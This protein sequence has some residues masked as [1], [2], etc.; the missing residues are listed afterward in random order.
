MRLRSVQLATFAF[1]CLL[2]T[3]M[4]AEAPAAF[5]KTSHKSS[6]AAKKSAAKKKAP[7][8]SI[9]TVQ[10]QLA[11]LGYYTGSVDGKNGPMTK[12]AVKDF[13]K[14]KGLKATGAL[15]SK[16][17][18]TLAQAAYTVRGADYYAAK[19]ASSG[20]SL[21]A[22]GSLGTLTSVEP[23]VREP[24]PFATRYGTFAVTEDE[25]AGQMKNYT[26]SL[27]GQAVLTVTNQA[28]PLRNSGTFQVGD[29]D[30]IVLTTY[31]GRPN[32]LYDN[33]LIVVRA[34]GAVLKYNIP[35]C[36]AETSGEV[37]DL[38]FFINFA[39]G[40]DGSKPGVIWRYYR[41]TLNALL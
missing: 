17:V 4:V 28:G 27:N 40:Y 18:S 9:H 7:S 26:L 6:A 10:S 20:R 19:P 29:E 37:K 22:G 8:T 31:T 41:G 5:A 1:A 30:A 3:A 12:R 32:C 25:V 35:V 23:V 33:N 15:D 34:D 39:D 11:D 21:S 24:D 38:S 2:G 13:Q 14:D 36:A 16:T